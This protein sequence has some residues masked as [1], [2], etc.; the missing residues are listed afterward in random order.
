LIVVGTLS[1]DG[2]TVVLVC[3]HC[4]RRHTHG[5]V[6]GHVGHRNAHCL[7]GFNSYYVEVSS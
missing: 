5:V 6:D 2:R 1:R 7:T 4:R 3:P